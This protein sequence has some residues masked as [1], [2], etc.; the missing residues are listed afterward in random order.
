MKI[1][2]VLLVVLLMGCGKKVYNETDTQDTLLVYKSAI[3]EHGVVCYASVT[4]SQKIS[5]IKVK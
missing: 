1:L 4:S 5:C 2:A 3:D